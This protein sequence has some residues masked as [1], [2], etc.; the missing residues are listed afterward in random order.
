MREEAEASPTPPQDYTFC[1]LRTNQS[2][3]ALDPA[4]ALA[5]SDAGAGGV[6]AS[7]HDLRRRWRYYVWPRSCCDGGAHR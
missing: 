1:T 3:P 7:G 6:I 2:R 4:F 5:V